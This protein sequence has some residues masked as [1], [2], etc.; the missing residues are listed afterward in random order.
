MLELNIDHSLVGDLSQKNIHAKLDCLRNEREPAFVGYKPNFAYLERII[1]RFNQYKKMIVIGNGGSVN[2]F[3]AFYEALRDKTKKEVFIL[4]TM[5]PDLL[6]QLKK[7][8]KKSDTIIM[9]IS[10]SGTNVGPLESLF[11]FMNSGY[12][13][14]FLTSLN[15]GALSYI[16]NA[17]NIKTKHKSV[18]VTQSFSSNSCYNNA[19]YKALPFEAECFIEHPPLGGRFAGRSAV[20]F[21]PAIFAGLDVRK[22]NKGALSIYKRCAKLDIDKNPALKLALALYVLENEGYS[23]VFMPVYSYALSGFNQLVIQLMHESVCK[24][25]VGQ[26][27]YAADAPESQHHTNQRFFGGKRNV[28]GLFVRALKQHNHKMCVKVPKEFRDIPLRGGKVSDLDR[29]P[30][31]K[32]LEF[33]FMGTIHDAVN[34]LIP[35]IVIT[36]DI[37]DEYSVGEMLGFWQY[38]AYYSALLRDVNPYDQ[39]QVEASKEIS[40]RLRKEYKR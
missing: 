14:V 8:F 1:A 11:A 25:Q 3:R 36:V 31:W 6:A 15:S 29:I 39:P 2:S 5:E 34:N 12:K 38:V 18:L 27:F 26:T 16:I 28:I 7:R 33:E 35:C 40:F 10:K 23:E 13:T 20:G 24:N 22:I 19:S 4:T 21:A 37:V 9:M 32:S 17:N 30:Y